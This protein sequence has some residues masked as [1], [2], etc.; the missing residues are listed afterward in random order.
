MIRLVKWWVRLQK[1]K[2]EDFRLKSFMTEMIVAHLADSGVS[3][4]DYA[5]SLE[6]VFTYI[7]KS[8]LKSRISF[9][10][11]YPAS[12]LPGLPERR[13]KSSTRSTKPTMWRLSTMR[14]IGRK[15]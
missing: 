4:A 15:S 12:K 2:D 14:A 11:Y 1:S 8:R 6:K 10:D 9:T 13:W 7:V 5:I 3:M